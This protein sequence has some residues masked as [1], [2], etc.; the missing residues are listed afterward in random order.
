MFSWALDQLF[1]KQPRLRRF[2]TRALYGSSPVRVSLLGAE[3]LIHS[4]L[5]N[6]YLRAFRRSRSLSLFRDETSILINLASLIGD[7]CT[8]LDIGANIGIYSAIIS[9]LG[10]VKSGLSVFAFEVDPKTFS[11]LAE[12]AQR[13]GFRAENVALAETEKTVDFVRGAVSHVTTTMN[14]RNRYNI[15]RERFTA[16]CVPLSAFDIPG[17][18]IVMKIDVE[19]GEYEVLLGAKALFSEGRV[20]AV[21][22]DGVSKLQETEDFLSGFGFRL[23][24]GKTLAP[25]EPGMFSLLAIRDSGRKT[26]AGREHS[27]VA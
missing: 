21:Y 8:F 9:R 14:A 23:L 24:D 10:R 27:Q 4:E 18:S 5:E 22:L 7:D 3:L 25:F 1:I 15:A 6:G 19:G 20:R 11:R 17:A 13:Y 26:G 16:R 12:N 2:V